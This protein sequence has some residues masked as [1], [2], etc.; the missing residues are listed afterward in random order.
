MHYAFHAAKNTCNI[1]ICHD[2]LWKLPKLFVKGTRNQI[3]ANLSAKILSNRGCMARRHLC[4]DPWFR[5]FAFQQPVG[6]LNHV[7]ARS[8][9][10]PVIRPVLKTEFASWTVL[11]LRPS[12]VI[13]ARKHN[14]R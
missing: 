8:V 13:A 5:F 4:G 10:M 14:R 1:G 7:S 2:S 6:A 12:R 3:T 9:L 11:M